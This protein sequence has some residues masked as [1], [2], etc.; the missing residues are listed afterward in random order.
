MNT[1]ELKEF[2]FEASRATYAAGDLAKKQKELDRSTTI[3]YKSG[4]YSYHDNYFGGEPYGGREVVF[5]DNKP[6]WMMV[7]YGF[8]HD[9]ANKDVYGFL[10]ESL[11]N[12]TKEMPYR[13]PVSFRKDNWRYENAL[14]GEVN[15][16]SGTEKIF[17]D[18]I[19]VY[20]ASY[21]GGYIDQP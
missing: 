2:I 5:F 19:C 12:N 3:R 7:Y 20:E 10:M 8:V 16:F 21:L 18:N 9:G 6:I 1:T 13:G 15:N 4:K 14:T 11:S 17:K